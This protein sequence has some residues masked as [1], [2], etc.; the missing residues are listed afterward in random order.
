[1][2]LAQR[3][4]NTDADVIVMAGVHFMAETAKLLNPDKI[5]LIPDMEAG[6]SLAEIDHRR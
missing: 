6:C 2:A 1:M 4:A 3:A 5:V